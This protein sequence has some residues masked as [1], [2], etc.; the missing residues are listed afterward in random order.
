[1][2]S[3]L[4]AGGK[5]ELLQALLPDFAVGCRRTTPGNGYLE[6]LCHPKCEV[7]WGK[8]NA[9][10]A[11]GLTTSDGT[12][13][14]RVDAIICATGFDLSCAPRFPIIGRNG[15]NLREEWLKNPHAYLSVTATDMPNYFTMMGPNSPLGHG[16]INGTVDGDLNSLH[17]GSRL[18][19]F[20][21]LSTPRYEDFEWQ[22][23]CESED[24]NFAWLA[25]GFTAAERSA[26]ENT[27]LTWYLDFDAQ[28][29][30]I[31]QTSTD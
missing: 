7:I 6:A 4:R 15:V 20:E 29:Q 17:P 24:M 10:T 30:Q 9:F 31:K 12:V 26:D 27:D 22:S 14:S 2:T 3:K 16:S 5:E 28:A 8:V 19:Y 1:M 23:L 18:H 13:T 11:D 25:T 21:L